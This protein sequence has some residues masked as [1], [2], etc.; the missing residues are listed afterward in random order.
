MQGGR[1][2]FYSPPWEPGDF[3]NPNDRNTSEPASRPLQQA[4][5]LHPGLWFP[6]VCF[7]F[8][9]MGE[10]ASHAKGYELWAQRI[11]LSR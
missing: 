9:G 2:R 7:G 1:Q 6:A 11:Q 8:D 4:H 10:N 5:L 3:E